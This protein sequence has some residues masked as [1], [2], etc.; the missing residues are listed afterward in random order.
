MKRKITFFILAIATGS[1]SLI[2]AQHTNVMISSNNF[3]NEP[4]IAI[5]PK[6]TN[7]LVAGSNIDNY[8]YS[9]DGGLTW[10]ED[11]LTSTYGVWGDPVIACDTTGSFYFFHLSNPPSGSWIDRIVCQRTNSPGGIWTPGTYTGLNGNK[12]Q[13]KHWVA[14]N[15]NT[16]GIYMTWTEFDAY[17]SNIP[18][19][20]SRIMFSRSLD[21]GQTWSTA[22]KINEVS[23]DCIDEDNT[24][25]GAVPAIGPNGE[26]YVAWAGPAG[27]VFDRSTDGGN[28][29]LSQDIFVSAI[30]GGWDFAIPGIYRA[31][32]LPIT[33]CD[34]SGGPNHGT[35]YINWT[36]QRNGITDTDVWLVKSV[37]GGNT[38]STPIKVND[39]TSNRQQFFT[40]MTLDQATG[41]LW[42]VF[43]DRR[44]YND[45][46]TDVYMARSADGGNTFQNFKISDT[47][48]I[49]T[50][51][52]FF[53]DYTNVTA[54]NNVVRPIWTRLHNGSLT[55]WTA[56]IDPLATGIE[57][58]N[59]LSNDVLLLEQNYPNPY[60]QQTTFSF[61]L[62]QTEEVTLK[63]YDF[64]G[65]CIAI[66]VN[67]E[68]LGYGKHVKVF[69]EPLATGTYFYELK[70]G[71]KLMRRK[72]LVID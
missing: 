15:K 13:D 30:P 6:N 26:V 71:S 9:T 3:P 39:D 24:T 11:L 57:N 28:T 29:W 10:T 69:D 72:M 5:N 32:G 64:F 49:P 47:P 55:L 44:N 1:C 54:H 56:I 63:V 31:N 67:K 16:N 34:L 14:I 68:T 4:S 12:A 46:R 58:N 50:P 37:D 35:I 52:V 40:W 62:H 59:G 18:T 66:P 2:N 25:E 27:L 7:E 53:G 8:Y 43:Y 20:S 17:G 42:F 23:G 45:T 48:F 33:T 61:K 41:E 70:A 21:Q 38:W 65:R 19:D 22:L 36:D 60:K 51:G